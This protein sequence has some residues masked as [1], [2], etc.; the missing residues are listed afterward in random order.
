MGLG[1][2]LLPDVGYGVVV[3]HALRTDGG[4][5]EHD[6]VLALPTRPVP[7]SHASLVPY[8]QVDEVQR[9]AFEPRQDP[10]A[11][12]VLVYPE[13]QVPPRADDPV[14]LARERNDGVLVHLTQGGPR[15]PALP[16]LVP[17]RQLVE[18]APVL[19]VEERRGDRA[20]GDGCEQVQAVRLVPAVERELRPL[21]L[22]DCVVSSLAHCRLPSLA[23]CRISRRL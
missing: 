23:S 16:S 22:P 1:D 10:L 14:E 8:D 19:R 20:V 3:P 15:L 12:V 13:E 6:E 7:H 11:E 5:L 17:V 9:G 2:L 18:D 21:G 4:L